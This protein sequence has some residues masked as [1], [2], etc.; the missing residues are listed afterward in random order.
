[1]DDKGGRRLSKTD[2]IDVLNSVHNKGANSSD[3]SEIKSSNW[4]NTS[5][6]DPYRSRTVGANGRVPKI[7]KSSN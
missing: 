7:V 5:N 3:K 2:R 6:L 4:F 1:M